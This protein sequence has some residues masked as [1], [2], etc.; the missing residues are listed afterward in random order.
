MSPRGLLPV[1]L[2]FLILLVC[3]P[4]SLGKPTADRDAPETIEQSVTL[5]ETIE[6]STNLAETIEES[7]TLTETENPEEEEDE[8]G[9]TFT[10][11][12]FT[13]GGGRCAK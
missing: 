1:P 2:L 9:A 4:N 5:P 10:H 11:I 13:I 8:V 12:S 3:V 7:T 6:E